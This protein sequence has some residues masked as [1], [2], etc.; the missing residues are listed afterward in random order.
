MW[1]Q[2]KNTMHV[3]IQN[4][5]EICR[6]IMWLY[7]LFISLRKKIFVEQY[8]FTEIPEPVK[9]HK[10]ISL[11]WCLPSVCSTNFVYSAHILCSHQSAFFPNIDLCLEFPGNSIDARKFIL[12]LTN[13]LTCVAASVAAPSCLQL[14][15]TV[16]VFLVR[17]FCITIPTI[18]NGHF[19]ETIQD[20]SCVLQLPSCHEDPIS[21]S[22]EI[23]GMWRF[24]L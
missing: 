23:V 8:Y 7:I 19:A 2:R 13:F 17:I 14:H 16:S 21:C 4:F 3:P 11:R 20:G 12:V 24:R 6:H 5:R 18:S 22:G 10:T 9:R 1:C 15:T